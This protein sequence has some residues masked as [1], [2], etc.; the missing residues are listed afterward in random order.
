[1]DRSQSERAVYCSPMQ[2][3]RNPPFKLLLQAG[4]TK[5]KRTVDHEACRRNLHSQAFL[6]LSKNYPRTEEGRARRESQAHS[7]DYA[8]PW[9]GRES[10]RAKHF[11]KPPGTSQIS[12]SFAWPPNCL[13]SPC[14]EYRYHVHPAPNRLCVL[15]CSH[16]LVQ[17]FGALISPLK[18][19]GN[20]LL[21]GGI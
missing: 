15:G 8:M 14:V 1:M 19:P 12:V 16:R 11:Q 17:S 9:F 18:Q 2:N 13:P 4:G 7:R 20:H 10:A 21:S 6:R 3:S 5:C